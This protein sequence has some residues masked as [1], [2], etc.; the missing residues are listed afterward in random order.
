LKSDLRPTL[1][2]KVFPF[3]SCSPISI[4]VAVHKSIDT[5]KLELMEQQ[6]LPAALHPVQWTV[7]KNRHASHDS[8]R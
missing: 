6:I 4:S 8:S 1:I 2:Q 3:Y 7:N 5:S